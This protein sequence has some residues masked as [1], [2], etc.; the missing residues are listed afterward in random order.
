MCWLI[1]LPLF[2]VTFVGQK[3]LATLVI[4]TGVMID[5][6]ALISFIK[7]KT[8]INPRSPQNTHQLVTTGLYHFSRNPMY[9]SLFCLLLGCGIWLDNP[10]NIFLLLMFLVVI[11]LF[12]LRPKKKS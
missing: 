6:I 7:A 1:V 10:L 8:T 12:Q 5:V 4:V 3:Q 9:L 2:A 11:S